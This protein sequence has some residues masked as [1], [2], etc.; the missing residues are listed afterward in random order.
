MNVGWT[1]QNISWTVSWNVCKL[2]RMLEVN[3]FFELW[4]KVKYQIFLIWGLKKY[5][6]IAFHYGT[7]AT[8]GLF[9]RQIIT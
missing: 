1:I 8:E 7:W 3:N 5:L 4:E 9:E 6:E 2:F